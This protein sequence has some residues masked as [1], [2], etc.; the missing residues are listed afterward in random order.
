MAAARFEGGGVKVDSGRVTMAKSLRKGTAATRSK[1]RV[2]A[3][4]C[5]RARDEAAVCSRAG[6]KDGSGDGSVGVS[7]ATAERERA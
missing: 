6:I 7:R 3:V 5:S 4:A 2:K 1:V